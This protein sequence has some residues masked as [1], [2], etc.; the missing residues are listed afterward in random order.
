MFPLW[1]ANNNNNGSSSSSSNNGE[2]GH[3]DLGTYHFTDGFR[4]K[5]SFFKILWNIV[6]LLCCISFRC[7]DVQ[8]SDIFLEK[9]MATHS[10][11]LAWEIT[12]TEE[13]DGP[14]SM[15]SQR[16]RHNLATE[17]QQQ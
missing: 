11:I 17:Q 13:V 16:V 5:I 2:S 15:R 3:S 10:S 9:E 1:L 8:Q 6:D 4:D 7:T 12:W 14:Q